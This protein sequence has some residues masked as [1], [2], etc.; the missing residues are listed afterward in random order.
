M[1]SDTWSDLRC[2][3]QLWYNDRRNLFDLAI[4]LDHRLGFA[5]AAAATAAAA[6][7]RCGYGWLGLRAH[8][9]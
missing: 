1:G 8:S 4:Y 6:G 5:A 9:L 2:L 7:A 3:L